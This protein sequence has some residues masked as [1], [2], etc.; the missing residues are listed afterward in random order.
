MTRE[1]QI[2]Y[3]AGSIADGCISHGAPWEDYYQG[4]IEGAKW[5]DAN[6]FQSA[7]PSNIDETVEEYAP[8]FSNDFASKAAVEAIRDAFKAGAKWMAGQGV[9]FDTEMSLLD[10][11]GFQI[12]WPEDTSIFDCFNEGDKVVVQIRKKQ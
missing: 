7:L 3:T 10:S 5:A 9:K 6:P 8:D 1:E 11:F 2:T 12:G 4:F